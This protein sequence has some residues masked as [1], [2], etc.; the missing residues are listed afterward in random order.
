MKQFFKFMFASMLGTFLTLVIMFFIFMGIVVSIVSLSSKNEVVISPN[1]VLQI[2]LD[3]PMVERSSMQYIKFGSFQAGNMGLDDVLKNIKKAANDPN[4]KGIY[5]DL[6]NVVAGM[7]SVEEIRNA[8]KEFKTSGKFIV[9]Y[10]EDYSQKAYYLASIS[11]KIYLNPEGQLTFKGISG[12]VMFMKGT[13]KKL[14]VDVQIIRHGKFKSAVEPFLLDKMSEPN[15]EQ[16]LTYITALW[17]QMLKGISESR[18]VETEQLNTIANSLGAQTA[19]EA[20]NQKLVDKLIYKDELI[21]ELKARCGKKESQKLSLIS[22]NKYMDVADKSKRIHSKDKIAVIYAA[23][24]I[25]SGDGDDQTVGSE[26]VSKAIR[27]ARLDDRVK[28]I[29]LRVNSPGGS[30]LASEV[31]YREII[32]A[33]KVKPVVVSMSDLAASG[34]YWISC[35]ANKI[36]AQ[37]NTITG[38]IGVFGMVPNFQKFFNNKLGITFDGVKTNTYSDFPNVNRALTPFEQNVFQK[39]VEHIYSLFLKHVSEGR[40]L[41]IAQVD[42]I[43]QGRVWSGADAKKIKLIDDFG[44]LDVAIKT[45]ANLA[46]ISD[47]RLLNL[48]KQKDPF[49]KLFEELT[50]GNEETRIQ[51]ELGDTYIYYQYLKS[52]KQM[53]GVQARLPYELMI[54]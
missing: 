6:D 36:I 28:A 4:I 51:K 47:Y 42:S 18:H 52:I 24:D 39:D 50:G 3:M 22:L 17:D 30:A 37:P 46:K 12:Q 1:S 21:A 43:G 13:L 35:A 8:L 11:D 15:R 14:D 20:F 53:K 48:P 23:G 7:A 5:L 2:K 33:K 31:I 44:G 19:E 10:S 29:V 41:T 49:T 26:P 45:A 54:D 25:V 38:S 40:N 16:T 27:E 32:L 9:S 34:G